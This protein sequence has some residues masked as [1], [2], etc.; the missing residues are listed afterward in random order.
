MGGYSF[1][2]HGVDLGDEGGVLI[3]G[4]F[5]LG[6]PFAGF[7]FVKVYGECDDFMICVKGG[8]RSRWCWRPGGID[9]RK[10][11]RLRFYCPR[12]TEQCWGVEFSMG[13]R[14]HGQAYWM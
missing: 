4:V 6:I 8:G 14:G 1:S 7:E 10:F 13:Q 2:D 9:W 5:D 3:E 11:W 12:S